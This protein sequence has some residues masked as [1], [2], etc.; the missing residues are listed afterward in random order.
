MEVLAAYSHTPDLAGLRHCANIYR[1]ENDPVARPAPRRPWNL[2][3]RLD[4]RT[5]ADMIAAYRAGT[6]AA[7]LATTHE[8]SLRSVTRLLAAAGVRRKL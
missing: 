2:R 8:L 4:E 1:P 6:T 5:R 7:S 3:D